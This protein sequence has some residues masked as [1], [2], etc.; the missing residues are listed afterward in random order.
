MLIRN[1]I[2]Q[3]FAFAIAVY[4]FPANSGE[5]DFSGYA[6]VIGG[7]ID[8]RN[9]EYRGYDD[10]LSLSPS[11][12]IGLQAEYQFNDKWS[13]TAQGL[14]RS[15]STTVSGE[16]GLEWLYLTYTPTDKL[17]IKAGK[18][19]TP[20]FTMSDFSDVGF[21]YP[22]INPPQQVYDTYLFKTFNGIDAIYK[23][24]SE[25]L[26]VSL[27]G[28]YGEE[29]GSIGI[30]PF[31]TGFEVDNLIGAIAKINIKNIEFRAS[32]YNGHIK[33]DLKSISKLQDVLA[34]FDFNKSADSL[35]TEGGA[36]ADQFGVIYDNLDYFFRGE[37]VRIKTELDIIPTI[38][39]YYLT[40]G[41]NNAPFTYHLTFADS[42]VEINS[43]QNEIPVGVSG[44]LD[45]LAFAYNSV[46]SES[47]PDSLKTWTVGIRWDV[48]PNLAL[49]AEVSALEGNEVDNSFFVIPEDTSFDRKTNLYLI[50][51]DWVF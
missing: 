30:G 46:F 37:W 2:L 6:R 19:R 1:K 27:E 12:L 29:S 40:V 25:D 10:S 24:G 33:L 7:Y 4:H 22:W 11:S 26:D 31:K 15:D 36:H 13:A 3:V 14:L 35:S 49:K 50:G 47:A 16:S 43:N 44:N 5:L 45:Q 21:A 34:D 48:L 42:D 39:S 17:Q 20:F 38:Q 9:V 51:L 8:E 18:L 41:Y 23:F 28:Y 32:R